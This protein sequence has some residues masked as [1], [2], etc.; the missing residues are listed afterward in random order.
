M[1]LKLYHDSNLE[2]LNSTHNVSKIFSMLPVIPF[3]L[4]IMGWEVS[5][6]SKNLHE[7]EIMNIMS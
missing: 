7:S 2:I 6:D 5:S 3:S 4:V 1:L